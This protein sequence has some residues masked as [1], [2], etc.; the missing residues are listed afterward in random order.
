MSS[1]LPNSVR[2]AVLSLLAVAACSDGPDRMTDPVPE[3]EMHF[4]RG[5][6]PGNGQRPAPLASFQVGGQALRAFGYA[7][8]DLSSN[9]RDPINLVFAGRS[10][11]R[12]IRA[13]LMGL[14]G[15]RSGSPLAPFDCT[16]KD[17]VGGLQAAWGTKNGWVGS[18]IQ[19]ECGE[20]G[21]VRFHLR[22]FDIG[23]VTLGGAHFEFLIPGTS[24]H[25]VVSWELAEQLVTFDLART[26]LLGAAP[27]SSGP[28]NAA[29]WFRTIPGFLHA[30]AVQSDPQFGALLGMLG[31]VD[32]ANG[33]KG[34]PTDGAATVLSLATAAPLV[35]GEARQEFE[36]GFGQVIP[37]PFC[38]DGAPS[39]YLYVT[40]PV[41]LRLT[42][43]QRANGEFS[44][45]MTA[46]GTL[47][48]TPVNPA[49][50]EPV[51]EPYSADVSEF[52]T[53]GIG[54]Q[55]ASI[56]GMQ[57]QVEKPSSAPGRGRLQ[58]KLKVGEKG[59]PQYSR[60][61]TCGGR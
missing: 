54:R 1:S 44:Q 19:L 43:V 26:G 15:N 60:R 3:L 46:A 34:I 18:A 20:Y 47:A 10:D 30:L 40:G 42:T 24:D 27:A 38:V 9:G 16:W 58:I 41:H 5:H 4:Q 13:A 51:G 28:V 14:D 59:V 31:L 23:N 55:G 33:D 22:F 11:P 61:E 29:P 17:A 39:P 57:H 36:V 52:Q 8:D 32:L 12:H 56:Q 25:Q 48:L 35:P 37:K 6:G 49:T 53:A 2:I 50:G 21:P 7:T 45:R